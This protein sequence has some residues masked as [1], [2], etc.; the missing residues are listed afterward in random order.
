M[1]EIISDKMQNPGYALYDWLYR[2]KRTSKRR[3]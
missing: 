1:F 2:R 3:S